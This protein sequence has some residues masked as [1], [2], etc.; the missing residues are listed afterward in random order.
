MDGEG[1]FAEILSDLREALVALGTLCDV[2]RRPQS[3]SASWKGI[4]VFSL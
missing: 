4:P 3:S 1:T 2:S